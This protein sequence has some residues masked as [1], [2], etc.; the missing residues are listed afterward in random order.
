[1]KTFT[2]QECEWCI[3]PSDEPITRHGLSPT[4]TLADGTRI[5]KIIHLCRDEPAGKCVPCRT[6]YGTPAIAGHYA[7]SGNWAR[8]EPAKV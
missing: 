8:T 3:P 7:W 6:S 5:H 1:M 4:E 2:E